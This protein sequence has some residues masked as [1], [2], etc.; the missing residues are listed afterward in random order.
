MPSS[1]A[2]GHRINETHASIRLKETSCS[3]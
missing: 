1:C 2:K 3:R